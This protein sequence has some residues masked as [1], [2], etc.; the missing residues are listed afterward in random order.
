MQAVEIYAKDEMV[1]GGMMP[2]I[3]QPGS[4]IN[5][6]RIPK[7][8]GD[9]P[10]PNLYQVATKLYNV[11]EDYPIMQVATRLQAVEIDMHT[12]RPK[13]PLIKTPELIH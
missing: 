7:F 4:F 1:W 2:E 6:A 8:E 11:T 12:G 13:E 5:I 9:K 3:P 10:P